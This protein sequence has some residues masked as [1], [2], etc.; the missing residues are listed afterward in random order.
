MSFFK[1]RN[2]LI[3]P[4]IECEEI[5]SFNG[6]KVFVNG[7]GSGIGLATAEMAFTHGA[8]V[9]TVS[10]SGDTTMQADMTDP[11]QVEQVFQAVGPVDYVLNNVGMYFTKPIE[12]TSIEEWREVMRYNLDSMFLATRESM[13]YVNPGGV[14]V[15]MASRPT[16][17]NYANWSAYTISK[18]G[19]IILTQSAAGEL[20]DRDVKAYA[21]CPSRVDTPF[22][23]AVFPNEA[24]ETRL[25]PKDVATAVGFLFSGKEPT[26]SYYWIKQLYG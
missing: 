7:A 18:V 3:E 8:N 22:R 25:D 20:K 11:K 4:P 17:D 14:I 23:Q 5:P 6:R 2:I 9:W 26:G 19:D 24:I 21:I 13:R 15:N 1:E 12:S 10:R 16:L